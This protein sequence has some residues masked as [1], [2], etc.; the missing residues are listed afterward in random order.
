[1]DVCVLADDRPEGDGLVLESFATYSGA[2]M[3]AL[4][5]I[6]LIVDED[7]SDTFVDSELVAMLNAVPLPLMSLDHAE[8][9]HREWVAE[10]AAS[11]DIHL[12]IETLE[13][14]R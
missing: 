5:K 2:L 10:W 9:V 11:T 3:A 12:N 4:A 1:M 6:V 8:R 13:V 14:Q 7:E